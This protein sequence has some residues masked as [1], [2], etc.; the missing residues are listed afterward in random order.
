MVFLYHIIIIVMTL[1]E[2]DMYL[3]SIDEVENRIIDDAKF[4]VV[5][6][7]KIKRCCQITLEI[8][9]VI[10]NYLKINIK[11]EKKN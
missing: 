1:A 2:Y 5:R 10:I 9:K 7:N 3:T 8:T 6:D 4:P 11:N